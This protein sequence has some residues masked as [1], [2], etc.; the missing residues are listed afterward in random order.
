MPDLST[1]GG[2]PSESGVNAAAS[3]GVTITANASANTKATTWTELIAATDYAANWLLISVRPAAGASAVSWL[4]DIGV[5]A[6]TAEQ[7]LIPNLAQ[8]SPLAE[9][10]VQLVYSF[11]LA[12]PAGTRISARCQASTGSQTLSV[13]AYAIST[14]IAA[15]PGLTRV[16]A[17]G[18]VTASSLPTLL[19]DPG[20]VAHTDGTWTQL[21]AAT[22]F[23]YKWICVATT[24]PNDTAYA[25]RVDDLLD[26]GVGAA[27]AEVE[28]MRDLVVQG[29]TFTD[30]SVMS[31]CFPCSIAA[32]QRVVAR[33]RCSNI[34]AGERRLNV[35]VYGAG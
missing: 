14:P 16:E 3:V 17:C 13:A 19:N 31:Y 30:M 21:I 9:K 27:A 4:M 7:V 28:V 33:H 18:A 12:I 32:G 11:P 24:N 22:G 1:I 34:T 5:G 25:V 23:A 35:A 29:D 6:S 20:G 26:I 15:P 10:M 8:Q 2:G